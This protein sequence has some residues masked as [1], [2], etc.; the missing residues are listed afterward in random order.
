MSDPA[1][2]CCEVEEI[3]PLDLRQI[4]GYLRERNIGRLEIKKR[5]V[6]HDPATVRKQLHLAGDERLHLFLTKLN[7][8][9]VAI[10]ARRMSC[11]I[12]LP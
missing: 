7:G 9:H 5:G 3:L 12:C 8:K 4:A 11:T 6:E 2:A 1:L 10:V